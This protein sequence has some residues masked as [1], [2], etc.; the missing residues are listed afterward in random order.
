[1]LLTIK[2]KIRVC[3]LKMIFKIGGITLDVKTVRHEILRY[4]TQ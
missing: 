3:E 1:M 4:K 2:D